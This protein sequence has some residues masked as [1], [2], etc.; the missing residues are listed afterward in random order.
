MNPLFDRCEKLLASIL[1]EKNLGHAIKGLLA[2]RNAEPLLVDSQE[3]ENL[4][5]DYGLMCDFMLQGYADSQRETMYLHLLRKAYRLAHNSM[6]RMQRA[7]TNGTI[8]AAWGRTRKVDMSHDAIKRGL[9]SFVQ[10]QAILSLNPD[11][12]EQKA[13][14]LH[15]RRAIFMK[16]LFD[17]LVA[18]LT[19]SDGESEFF[20]QNFKIF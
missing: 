17:S 19:G 15:R 20:T 3:M 9:E 11:G 16:N 10:D 14:E 2:I 13:K 18:S 1:Q 6:I 12:E 4:E 5:R 7:S 8:A